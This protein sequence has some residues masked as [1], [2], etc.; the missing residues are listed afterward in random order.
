M[1]PTQLRTNCNPNKYWSYIRTSVL[2]GALINRGLTA[3]VS[4]SDLGRL[5]IEVAQGWLQ[6]GP[7]NVEHGQHH[8]STGE[9]RRVRVEG[10]SRRCKLV[11]DVA[12]DTTD[13]QGK[14]RANT[15]AS[16]PCH[17]RLLTNAFSPTPSHQSLIVNSLS[18]T[19]SPQ[20]LIINATP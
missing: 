2:L 1:S 20:R 16:T 7:T 19:P 5:L 10:G 3:Q 14:P 17:Q 4:K 6:S 15:I 8:A 9:C 11:F 18:S 13:E 12:M